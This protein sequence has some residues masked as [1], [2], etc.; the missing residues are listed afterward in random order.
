VPWAI[1]NSTTSASTEAT[2]D[3]TH[4][5][6]REHRDVRRRKQHQPKIPA[7]RNPSPRGGG[8]GR[9]RVVEAFYPAQPTHLDKQRAASLAEFDGDDPATV[10][11]GI[12]WGENVAKQ[13][14]VRATDGFSNPVPQFSG[15]GA[16]NCPCFVRE[17]LPTSPNPAQPRRL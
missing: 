14:G 10:Q 4:G 3:H 17:R 9:L 7:G 1:S 6:D 8:A 11:R 16:V 5:G 2:A 15:A 12:A 13:F